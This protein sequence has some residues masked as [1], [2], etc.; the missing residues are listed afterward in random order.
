MWG[1]SAK[2]PEVTLGPAC[3]PWERSQ[4]HKAA[5]KL[6]EETT[7]NEVGTVAVS[8][9]S[10]NKEAPLSPFYRQ[11]TDDLVYTH[12]LMGPRGR[13]DSKLFRDPSTIH[14]LA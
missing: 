13:R 5:E 8:P 1:F 3:G 6:G 11:W 2:E 12:G 14:P 4:D 10:E 7:L 9:M